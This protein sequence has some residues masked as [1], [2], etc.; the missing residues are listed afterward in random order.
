VCLLKLACRTV[1]RF[2]YPYGWQSFILAG[3]YCQA[4]ATYPGVKRSGPLLLPYLVLLHVGFALPDGLLR[5]R[6]ALTA[7][8]HPYPPKRR[9]IFCCTFREKRF[10]R[11]PPAV[12]R[13]AVLRR[14]DFPLPISGATTRPA[15]RL[16]LWHI[17]I[18]TA[19]LFEYDAFCWSFLQF[20]SILLLVRR[21]R[22][23][24]LFR[25]VPK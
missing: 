18:S 8:F 1:S 21:S 24:S 2:L 25:W 19:F 20:G 13:H 17:R 22:P 7:P 4:L 16:P 15:S 11:I 5:P 9:Y 14:P 12:S 10:K 23:L 6:C 3:H